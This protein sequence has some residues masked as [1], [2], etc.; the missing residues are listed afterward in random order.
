MHINAK[1]NS[2]YCLKNNTD[3]GVLELV[4]VLQPHPQEMSYFSI[5]YSGTK[6]DWRRSK[7]SF[8]SEFSKSCQSCRLSINSAEGEV[9]DS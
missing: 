8:V 5:F 3:I 2:V 1:S 9:K 7:E 6:H 4:A